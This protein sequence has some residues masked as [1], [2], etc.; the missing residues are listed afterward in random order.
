MEKKV[1]KRILSMCTVIA[2]VLSMCP[3]IV[4]AEDTTDYS[5]YTYVAFG[6]SITYGIDGDYASG[7]DGY[8]M[9][10][11]Y[12]TLV[13]ETLGIG[14]VVNQAKSG[15]TWT[16]HATRTNMT[17]RIMRY[18]GDADII[19]VMLGVNDYAA[20]CVL[21]D[22][23]SR[24]NTTIYGSIH[25]AAK[26]LTTTYPDAFIFFMTPFK[27]RTEDNGQYTLSDVAQAVKD[28]A[29][30][31]NIPVL[32]MYTNGQ[33]DPATGAKDQIHPTQA[34]HITYT[35]PM[36]CELICQ[37]NTVSK[38]ACPC[39]AC[40][41]ADATW[42]TWDGTTAFENGKHYRLADNVQLTGMITIPK[43]TT[44]VLD[45]NGK[46]ITAAADSRC[47]EVSGELSIINSTADTDADGNYT[48]LIT[49]GVAATNDTEN[50]LRGGN[51]NIEKG[52]SSSAPGGTL[53]LYGGTIANGQA[54]NAGGNVKVGKFAKFYMYGGSIVDG[55]ASTSGSVGNG[56]NMNVDN[57]ANFYMYGGTI[58]GGTAS[59]SGG[60]I[61]S[62]KGT[63]NLHD[64]LITGGTANATGSN[65]G[66]GN[67]WLNAANAKLNM[68]GGVISDGEAKRFGGNIYL[69]NA[70]G[71]ITMEGGVISGGKTTQHGGNIFASAGTV[72]MTG[73][74]IKD[75]KANW[76]TAT[77]A[78]TTATN[79]GGN[80]YLSGAKAYLGGDATVTGGSVGTATNQY[81]GNI[82]MTTAAELYLYDQ[83]QIL[84]GDAIDGKN[85]Y[86]MTD[87][88]VTMYGG[89]V[90]NGTLKTYNSG[91]FHMYGGQVEDINWTSDQGTQETI[92]YNGI[93]GSNTSGLPEKLATWAADCATVTQTTHVEGHTVYAVYQTNLTNGACATCGHTYSAAACGT[94]KTY[95]HPAV[96]VA[97]CEFCD[98]DVVW[99]PLLGNEL[100]ADHYYLAED[101]A[102]TGKIGLA[103]GDAVCIDL[104]GHDLTTANVTTGITLTS[105]LL[106]IT[107][108]GADASAII[109]GGGGIL[110]ANKASE[111]LRPVI[112]FKNVTVTGGHSIDNGGN[113]STNAVDLILDNC[114]ITG[115]YAPKN[116]GNVCCYATNLTIKGNTQIASGFAGNN[117]DDVYLGTTAKAQMYSGTVGDICQLN[118]TGSFHLYGGTVGTLRIYNYTNSSSNFNSSFYMYG[119]TV[120]DIGVNGKNNNKGTGVI[121]LYAGTVGTDPRTANNKNTTMVADCSCLVANDD[122][123]YTIIHTGGNKP[124][125]KCSANDVYEGGYTFPEASLGEHTPAEAVKENV[126]APSC[127]A[128]GAYELVTYCDHCGIEL[129]RVPT[130]DPATG[131]HKYTYTNNGDKT[132]TIGCENCDYSDSAECTDENADH[133][134]DD[135]GAKLLDPVASVNGV[136]YESLLEAWQH[137]TANSTIT[138]L[139]DVDMTGVEGMY[140]PSSTLTLDLNGKTL[141]VPYQAIAFAGNGFTIKNGTIDSL[142]ASY[143]LWIGGFAEAAAA[144]NVTIE[145]VTV[146]GGI[147]IK[148]AT[149]VTLNNVTA[150][151]IGYYAVWAEFNASGVVINSGSYTGAEGK[152]AVSAANTDAL[153]VKGGTYSSNVTA[154]CEEGKHTAPEGSVYVYGDHSYTSV[155]AP[156]TETTN[157]CTTYTCVCGDSYVIEEEGTVLHF[158]IN[159]DTGESYIDLQEAISAAAKG[160]TVKLLKDAAAEELYIGVGKKLDLNGK[161]LVVADAISAPFAS[162]HIIDTT[163]GKGVIAVN[164]E[165]LAL[166]SNNE[167]LP[168]WTDEGVKFV[169]VSF[170]EQLIFQDKTGTANENVGFYSFY[171]NED[172]ADTILDDI[173]KNGTEG[174]GISIRVKVEYVA[175]NGMKAT[176][177]FVYSSQM[178]FNYVNTINGWDGNAFELYLTGVEDLQDLTFSAEIVSAAEVGPTV[179]IGSTPIAD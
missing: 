36:I 87:A 160:Q 94:C 47:F 156:A 161:K 82:Y 118:S 52:T 26:H 90:K 167:Y 102:L 155:Y 153:T 147:N 5:G 88:K 67:I 122:G 150:T 75:G 168:L 68:Y 71:K 39:D 109:S 174:T 162:T 18:N 116:G 95:S 105:A 74:V 115:G 64:G 142:G 86:A 28:V 27:Y 113:I 43:G 48:G 84:N 78:H 54:A 85:I 40:N 163:N 179:V 158:A 145:D 137:A 136:E 112:N 30:V 144:S 32:D 15:A 132:H 104:N 152:A 6:D 131:A 25:M 177:H 170:T 166:N 119:G 2:L 33:F 9:A 76:D 56:G 31:Y 164:S 53:K 96:K 120:N 4:F 107:N 62:W 79:D 14:T 165:D 57:G 103:V 172:A 130:V 61:Y 46:T 126:T 3:T 178:V 98:K 17:E 97:N 93:L 34:H 110:A 77:S 169:K 63:I 45:L 91:S 143:G 175:A 41:G 173:L 10:K 35:A 148:N 106:N 138:L 117:G 16:Q 29:A 58:S 141:K 171:F 135:C 20:K 101:V 159:T 49:G 80:I 129:S 133:N 11:P 83:A 60:N 125:E 37:H 44:V 151:G 114:V 108:T 23:N 69:D 121:A 19:S 22:M 70:S 13:A 73:G 42:T 124:C 140:V 8:R 38:D 99:A 146:I 81:G 51:I 154:F 12:P 21:G 89:T 65:R 7:E 100:V 134:C 128:A 149:N 55:T 127:G 111:Q 59:A 72:Q 157:A 50:V 66:G 139:K 92:I 1:W 123:T 24:D 176:Q